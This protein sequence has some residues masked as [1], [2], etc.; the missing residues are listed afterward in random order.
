MKKSKI[1]EMREF[2]TETL[3]PIIARSEVE[4]LTGG[5]VKRSTLSSYD[6]KGQGVSNLIKFASSDGI[7][8]K[9]AY[10][11]DDL[12]DW[13]VNRMMVDDTPQPQSKAA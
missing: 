2:L 3:P 9:V 12:I 1:D 4:K 13:I 6:S 8:G 10:R 5:L 7:R 11:R